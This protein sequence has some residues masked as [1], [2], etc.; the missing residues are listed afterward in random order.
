[1]S[2]QPSPAPA[3][4]PLTDK[5]WDILDELRRGGHLSAYVYW[6][7]DSKRVN[8]LECERLAH[9]KYIKPARQ[10]YFWRITPAGRAALAADTELTAARKRPTH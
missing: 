3:V 1:M 2:K 7:V 4:K 5:Q 6:S 9:M 10:A 8:A